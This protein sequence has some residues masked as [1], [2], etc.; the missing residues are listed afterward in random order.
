MDLLQGYH[1]GEKVLFVDFFK[2][3][4]IAEMLCHFCPIVTIPSGHCIGQDSVTTIAKS[5]KP[6]L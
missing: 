2:V 3:L 6:S 4:N 1:G 5:T